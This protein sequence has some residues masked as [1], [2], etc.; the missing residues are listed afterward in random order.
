MAREKFVVRLMDG[1]TLLA[2]AEVYASPAPQGQRRSC[3]FWP[4]GSTP[5]VIDRAG[6]ASSLTVHWCD[7]DLVRVCTPIEPVAVQVGQ[8]FQWTWIEPIWLVPASEK[9]VVLPAVTLRA[10]VV[11]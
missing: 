7:L 1:D 4:E 9:D 2:W 11:V 5:L 10:P 6:S 3:P 8:V